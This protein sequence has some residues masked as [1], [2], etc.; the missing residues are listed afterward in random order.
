VPVTNTAS[1]QNGD[2]SCKNEAIGGAHYGPVMAYLTKVSDAA[3]ADGS[4]GWYKI[5]ED[6][7]ATKPGGSSDDD[8]WG[9]K[10][11]N[12]CC[13]KVDVPIPKQIAPGD[14]L[15][16][17]EVIALHTAGSSGGAQL[18]MSCY[19][20]TI[21][22]NG[23]LV[24]TATVKFPGAYKASD[25]GILFNIHAKAS[26]YV[27][28]GPSVIPEGVVKSA[29]SGCNAGGC[30][31]TCTAGKGPTGTAILS[32]ATAAVA[33]AGGAAPAGGAAAGGVA[34]CASVRQVQAWQQCGGTGFANDGCVQC[35][36]SFAHT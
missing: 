2:R 21:S 3:T 18:Y 31:A 30:M 10:D 26:T 19:Q 32:K 17:A 15:L 1:K 6:G 28:P 36:V 9:V 20:I 14:Y 7:W 13:G 23:T 8:Y 29:G 22:G 11:M 34:G 25:P 35:P 5:Y 12:T 24:P 33:A 4:T 27:V 16:R